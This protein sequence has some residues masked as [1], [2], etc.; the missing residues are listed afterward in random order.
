MLL[1]RHHRLK[2]TTFDVALREKEWARGVAEDP[3]RQR[4]LSFAGHR[5]AVGTRSRPDINPL[6][7][8]RVERVLIPPMQR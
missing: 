7:T 6:R 4:V 5:P 3:T 8:L 1:A 2:L